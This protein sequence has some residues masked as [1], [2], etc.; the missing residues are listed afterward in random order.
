MANFDAWWAANSALFEKK[1][2]DGSPLIPMR[3]VAREA[4]LRGA[5]EEI[6]ER[7]TVCTPERR[8]A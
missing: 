1:L 8:A 4:W 3:S 2:P 7:N 6:E 5:M